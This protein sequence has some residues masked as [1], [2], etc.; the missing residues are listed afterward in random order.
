M[1]HPQR[2]TLE[3]LCLISDSQAVKDKPRISC[4]RELLSVATGFI[5]IEDAFEDAS[6]ADE[7]NDNADSE[8][9]KI[10]IPVPTMVCKNL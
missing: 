1:Q 5:T 8:R 7:I 10:A 2:L 3:D 6:D 4:I 9:L